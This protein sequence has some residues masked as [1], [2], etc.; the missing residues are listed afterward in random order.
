MPAFASAYWARDAALGTVSPA[1]AAFTVGLRA[2]MIDLQNL[3]DELTGSGD[4]H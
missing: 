2:L 3:F 4:A 1:D